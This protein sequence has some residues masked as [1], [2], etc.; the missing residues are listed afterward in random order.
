MARR[1]RKRE[2]VDKPAQAAARAPS[3]KGRQS[4]R[5]PGPAPKAPVEEIS[6]ISS[7]E[8]ASWAAAL[9][10][11]YSF[12]ATWGQF[13][14]GNLMG[15]YSMLADAL[16]SG[17]LSIDYTPDEVHLIDM[18]PFEGRYYLQWGPVPALF[19]LIAKLGGGELT[20]RVACILA[21]WL[22]S[23]A[24]LRI[25]LTIR[26][27]Y[28]PKLPLWVCRA[29]FVAF[30]LGSPTAFVSLRGTIYHESIGMTA[31]FVVFGFLFLL[32]QT[33]KPS[34][35]TSLLCGT[36]FALAVGTRATSVLNAGALF[37]GMAALERHWRPGITTSAKRLVAF[38]LPVA[39]A[40]GMMLTYNQARFG[41]MKDFGFR[42]MNDARQGATGFDVRRIPR[43][44]LHYLAAPILL[45]AELPWIINDGWA[46]GSR[47]PGTTYRTEGM[48]SI[49]LVTPFLL[50]GF[51]IFRLWRGGATYPKELA[52]F[53]GTTAAASALNF[54]FLLSF[55]DTSRRYMQDFVPALLIAAFIGAG[56]WQ[57]QKARVNAWRWPAAAVLVYS[58]ILHIHLSFTQPFF[59]PP[60]DPSAMKAFVKW[61]PVARGL[62][63]WPQLAKDEAV[64]RNDLGVHYL[65]GRRHADAL[66]QF[67]VANQLLPGSPVVEKN[68]NLTRAL[69]RQTR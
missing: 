19:H 64:V 67:E 35:G 40:C 13:E 16:L 22:T 23:L 54:L 10:F 28:F 24:F 32:K 14:F 49:F 37:F 45:Q 21:G 36:F 48:A 25:N 38:S 12:I 1:A 20:D 3:A 5:N 7:K 66:E 68:L 58:A 61:G 11:L 2:A 4:A 15:Y 17:R 62:F 26:G 41:S 59:T 31:M 43:N 44:L 6:G 63:D 53:G 69:L 29:F 42:H 33:A 30:A 39:L 27:R 9:L 52:I 60:P 65:Q 34:I 51:W 56:L 8:F 57:Q 55:S 47:P 18:I 46:P 50:F